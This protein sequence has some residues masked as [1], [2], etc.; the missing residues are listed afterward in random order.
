MKS[1]IRTNDDLYLITFLLKTAW[2]VSDYT[3]R[4]KHI[5]YHHIPIRNSNCVGLI[6]NLHPNVLQEQIFKVIMRF[7]FLVNYPGDVILT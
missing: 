3:T 1:P 2:I 6:C 7:Y 5:G 4:S